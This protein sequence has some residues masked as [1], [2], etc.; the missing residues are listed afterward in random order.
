MER[1]VDALLLNNIVDSLRSS[2]VDSISS[3]CEFLETVVIYD[4]PAEAFLQQRELLIVSFSIFVYF[5]Y[6]FPF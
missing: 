1:N 3:T 4:F 5:C 2:D 6:H